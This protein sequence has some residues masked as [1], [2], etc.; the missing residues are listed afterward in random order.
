MINIQNSYYFVKENPAV[1]DS[2]H[3]EENDDDIGES[4]ES[5]NKEEDEVSGMELDGERNDDNNN[6]GEEV[7]VSQ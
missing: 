6:G 2:V 3:G 4:G 7:D 1:I 5:D